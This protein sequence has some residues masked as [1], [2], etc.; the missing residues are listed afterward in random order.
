MNEPLPNPK[1]IEILFNSIPGA[2]SRALFALAYLTAGRCNEVLSLEE[3][4]FKHIEVGGRRLLLIENMKNSKNRK[5]KFKDIPL[6]LD[7]HKPLMDFLLTYLEARKG[8]RLFDFYTVSRAEQ[9]LNEAV[10]M[11]PHFIRHVR[12]THLAKYKQFDPMQLMKFAGWTTTDLVDR[13][14]NYNWRDLV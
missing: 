3:A 11:N 9:L 1:E 5:K 7:E 4:Q 12:L 6:P 10:G 8:K 2:R 13:Y 14:I